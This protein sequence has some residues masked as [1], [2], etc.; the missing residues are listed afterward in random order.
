V[1]VRIDSTGD[2]DFS[3]CLDHGM[4]LIIS[5]RATRANCNNFF[6]VYGDFVVTD[7][8]WCHDC[9]AAYDQVKHNISPEER[10]SAA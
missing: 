10:L 4:R 7:S 5:K 6:L 9:I 2:D 3:G 1:D 8:A